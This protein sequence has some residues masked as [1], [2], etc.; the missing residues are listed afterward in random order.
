METQGFKKL[1]LDR[2]QEHVQQNYDSYCER[3]NLDK[4][5]S[6]RLITFLIDQDLIPQSLIQR[7]AIIKE[8][9]WMHAKYEFQKTQTVVALA[10]RFSISERTVWSVLKQSKKE[11]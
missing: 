4:I 6:G 8:F 3:N 11:G 9:E 5:N 2:F 1:I 7:Y 10:D